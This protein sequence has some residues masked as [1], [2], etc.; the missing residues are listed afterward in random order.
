[1]LVGRDLESAQLAELL[2]HARHGSSGSLVV[3]GEPGVG[4]SALLEELVSGASEVL[5]LRT[6]GLE[7]ESPLAFA[8]LH[9]LL[10]PVMRLREELPAPQAR[11]LRVAF[12]EQDGPSIEPFLVA[13]ATL[14]MLT[15]AAEESTV[16][17]V[18]EDAHW[19]DSA[20]ADALLFCARRLGADRVLLVFSAR[21]GVESPFRPDGIADL[22]LTGLAPVAARELLDQRLGDAAV[23]EVAER[24]IAES[25]GNP[26]ALLELPTELS[27]EQLGGASP[28]PAQLHLTTRVEQAFLDR[29]RLLPPAVQ[30]LLLLAAA[31]DTGQLAVVRLA[32]STL[33][34]GEQALDLAVGSGLLLAQ[35][36]SVAV[37]HPLVRSALYQA[38]S[39]QQRRQVHQALADALAGLGD[40]DREAWH[41]ASAAQGPDPDVVAALELVGSR[42]ERRGAYVSALAAYER[43]AALTTLSPQ[44]AALTLAAA[45]NAWASGQIARARALLAATRQFAE[46]PV[47][48]SDVARLQ[49]R[50]EVNIGSAND[51]HRIF[52]EAA[53]AIHD[54]D[55]ARALE[56]AV[57]AAIMGTYGAD[58]GV[59]LAPG[60]IDTHL[61]GADSARSVCLKQMLAAMDRAAEDDWA[62]AVAALDIAL[63]TGDQLTDL[64]VLGNLGNAALQLG[65]DQSQ[66]HFYSLALSRAREAGAV[67]AVVYALQRLC[68]GY[69]VAGDWATV[70]ASAQEALGLATSMGARAL[71]APPLAWLTLLAALQGRDDYEDLLADL[72]EVVAVHPLGIL[73]DPVHDLT[74]W[75]RGVRAAAAADT[76]GAV[77]HLSQMR[78]PVLARMAATDRIDAAVRAGEPDLAR[79]WVANDLAD[80][81]EATG[82]PW[83]L[84][85]VAYGR[86]MTSDAS[87]SDS[88]GDPEM[89]FKAALAHHTQGGRSYDQ[90]RTHLAYGEWLRRAQRRL[91]A[92]EHLRHALEFFNDVHALALADR[93]SAE[94]RASGETARKRD[95]STQVLLTP[96]ELK[97]AQMVSSGLSNKEVAAQIWVSPRTVAFHLRNVFAKA[98]V[99]SRGELAQLELT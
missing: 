56:M 48:L 1:V 57:A 93:A 43:A 99:S 16:L 27:L 39:G 7:V 13:V 19:L 55:P 46:D 54:I 83:A 49:A 85:A 76:F 44:R 62:A 69:L 25:G 77:H 41:R 67:M 26:L 23:A 53:H 74:R 52:T 73:T 38:A 29:S 17:A 58:G 50:I 20:T 87:D 18:V 59:A 80:F 22:E 96:M 89:L 6:Q 47:L 37:R 30:S 42:A 97:V 86:A 12:G 71:T 81:A 24:L 61:T 33:G 64:D 32:A 10:L 14:S 84:A 92:R 3:R 68:F 95:P 82:R 90:A 36:E 28:L 51:A 88:P 72:E 31:D 4:K 11:A 34:L 45:R 21:D 91:D 15:A 35:A 98:G 94:L 78:L 63:A 2:D 40:S 75:A 9:R 5:V 70:R 79:R 8:A 65:D 60:D 66:Q